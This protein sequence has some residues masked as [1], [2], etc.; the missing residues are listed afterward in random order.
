VLSRRECVVQFGL[1]STA[2]LTSS[3]F[4]QGAMLAD[5]DQQTIVLGYKSEAT[6]T[7]KTKFPKYAQGQYCGTCALFQ[8]KTGDKAGACPLYAGKKFSINGWCGGNAKKA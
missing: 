8:G 3:A 1:G 5:S 2:L 4:A 6:K 7:D